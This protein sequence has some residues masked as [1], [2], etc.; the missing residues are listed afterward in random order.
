MPTTLTHTMIQTDQALDWD[1]VSLPRVGK[2]GLNFS[3]K[4]LFGID[5]R[6]D[7]E[8]V[9]SISLWE[10][11]TGGYTLAWTACVDDKIMRNAVVLTSLSDVM[12]HLEDTCASQ[13]CHSSAGF[14]DFPASDCA[15]L[16]FISN[17]HRRSHFQLVFAAMAGEALSVWDSWMED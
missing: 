8:V 12:D 5:R 6:V 16:P 10:R 7:S 4:L 1:A 13:V 2:K 3:G 14:D 11:Q 15:I 9:A 17:L